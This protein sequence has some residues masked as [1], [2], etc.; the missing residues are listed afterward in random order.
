MDDL[1]VV[2]LL[3]LLA[4]GIWW[5]YFIEYRR[6]RLDATRQ[7]LFQIRDRL[8]AEAADGVLPID[9]KAHLILRKMFNGTIRY[10]HRLG[11]IQIVSI[12]IAEQQVRGGAEARRFSQELDEAIRELSPKGRDAVKRARRQLHVT[13]IEHI[14][15]NSIFLTLFYILFGIVLKQIMLW[16]SIRK[17]LLG[18][19]SWRAIDAEVESIGEDRAIAA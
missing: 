4:L 3:L 19:K 5:L 8:F 12:L 13:V 11:F 15:F 7:K 14:V 1:I 16:I 18:E 2:T 9:S 6:Y 10:A 17:W